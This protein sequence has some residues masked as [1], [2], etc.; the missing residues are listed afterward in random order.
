MPDGS[1]KNRDAIHFWATLAGIGFSMIADMSETANNIVDLRIK[2]ASQPAVAVPI[3]PV[4][5]SKENPW[6]D[7]DWTSSVVISPTKWTNRGWIDLDPPTPD[8]TSNHS[9]PAKGL[10][11]FVDSIDG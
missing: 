2:L 9:A 1:W 8:V 6:R 3:S 5:A 7:D 10:I 4:P 11:S